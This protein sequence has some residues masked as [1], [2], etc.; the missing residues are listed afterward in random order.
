MKNLSIIAF[1]FSVTDLIPFC[2][3]KRDV[4]SVIKLPTVANR[5]SASLGGCI[6]L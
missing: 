2:I 3:K 6:C 5:V 4:G 1:M